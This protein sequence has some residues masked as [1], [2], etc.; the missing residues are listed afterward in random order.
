MP[1]RP[2]PG[3]AAVPP[4][5]QGRPAPSGGFKLSSNEN[6]FPP[7]PS[8]LDAVSEQVQFV[9][10][11]PDATASK[12]RE[13][14]SH[15]LGVT[16]DRLLVTDGSV[17]AL[18]QLLLAVAETGDEVV[19]AWRSFEAYPLLVATTGATSVQV[20]LRADASHDL[21]AMVA[22]ITP[23]TRAIIV[24]SP[25]N[26]TGTLVRQAEWDAFLAAVPDDVLV[27]LDE[28]YI[29][30]VQDSEAIDGIV[31]AEQAN[32]V[33]VRTFSKA[34]GLAGLRVGY[35]IGD[36][37]LL[38]AVRTA[39]IPLSVTGLAQA[40]ATASL[41]AKGELFAR[42][43]TLIA[44]RDALREALLEIGLP[45]PEAHGNFLWIPVPPSHRDAVEDVL[46]SN[47]IVARH[48]PEGVRV[49]IGE[50]AASEKIVN[51]AREIARLF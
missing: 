19:Y 5:A 3:I 4:Y 22:A 39:G 14:L 18:A 30:F 40:A 41:A 43:E 42:V 16:T 11:Y 37:E 12:L 51:S 47:G 20:P 10:L 35:A 21:E 34:Y 9:N 24:C 44:E 1:V 31:A 6:P 49:S 7:L 38:H 2:R 46:H 15:E 25:N 27:I 32:V 45:V 29:E 13:S 17:A 26:P 50:H 28:A 48:F 36:A 33:T 23:K 8:V